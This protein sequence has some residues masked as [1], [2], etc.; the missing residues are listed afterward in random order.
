[1]A[2]GADSDRRIAD[3]ERILEATRAIGATV[4]LDD[5]LGRIAAAAT[6]VLDCERATVF[7]LDAARGELTSRV[8]TGIA[9]SPIREIRFGIDRGV[10]GE[11]ARTGTGVNIAAPYADHRFNP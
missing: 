5:L 8:A 2:G 1:M 4:D 9:G 10:A 7:L 6:D 11:V 3:L